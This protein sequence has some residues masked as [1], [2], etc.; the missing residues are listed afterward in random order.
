MYTLQ[1]FITVI[2]KGSIAAAADHEH[3]A[4]SALSKRLS[5]L[6]RT[7][8]SPL[9]IRHA[10]GVEPTDAGYILARGARRLLHQ[11]E[12]LADELLDYSHGLRGNVRI[13]ANLSS[14]SQFL[15]IEIRQFLRLYPQVQIDL[16]EKISA[17]VTKA[18][19]EN[20]ADIGIFTQADDE[21]GLRS[22]E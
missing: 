22:E 11:A 3:I 8:G 9:L 16:D 12:D 5:A 7:F 18:V 10:R 2:E 14:I 20:K 1:V 13:S 17:D 21:C 19:A 6:E 4:P 15:P